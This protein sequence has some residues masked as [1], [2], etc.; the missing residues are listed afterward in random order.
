MASLGSRAILRGLG[1]VIFHPKN[2]G[3]T[4]RACKVV[5]SLSS[6]S[7][8]FL[9]MLERL[10]D[11]TSKMLSL[12]QPK[13]TNSEINTLC[14]PRSKLMG[15]ENSIMLNRPSRTPQHSVYLYIRHSV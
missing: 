9:G 11:I 7:L 6:V 12:L 3:C 2:D 13:G 8:S 5:F 14:L 1:D 4:T 15:K 10:D